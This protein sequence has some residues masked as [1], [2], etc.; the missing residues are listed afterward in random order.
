MDRP[1]TQMLD[2]DLDLELFGEVF[3]PIEVSDVP[4]IG[5]GTGSYNHGSEDMNS[6]PR[7]VG[8]DNTDAP[9]TLIVNHDF[10]NWM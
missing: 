4:G 9:A 6:T 10:G 1:A 8:E 2:L 5:T 7:Q 3:D